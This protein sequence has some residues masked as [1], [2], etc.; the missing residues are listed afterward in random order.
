MFTLDL[1]DLQATRRAGELLGQTAA[2]GAVIVLSGDLGAGKTE[3]TRGLAA[4][5][6][7]PGRITSP[8]F[9]V[10]LVHAGGRLGLLHADLYRVADDDELEQTGLSDLLDG[11]VV[12]VIEWGERFAAQLPDDHLAVR[13]VITGEESR[14]L[15]AE[16]RG[17]R[18]RAWEASLGR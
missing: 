2:A 17:P 14:R 10:V 8:T 11:E 5:L 18:S 7:V 12:A 16:G 13:L 1:P 4:G 15:Q 3:L 9:A 6:G